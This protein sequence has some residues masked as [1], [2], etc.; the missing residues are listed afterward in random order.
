MDK[1]EETEIKKIIND[2][3][4]EY[5]VYSKKQTCSIENCNEKIC[6]GLLCYEHSVIHHEISKENDRLLAKKYKNRINYRIC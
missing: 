5:I 1:R 6:K 3:I 2:H 4:D